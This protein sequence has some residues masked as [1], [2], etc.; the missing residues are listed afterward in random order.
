MSAQRMHRYRT[1][2][3][4]QEEGLGLVLPKGFGDDRFHRERNKQI[5]Q[6]ERVFETEVGDE[7]PI[8]KNKSDSDYADFQEDV[9]Y[10]EDR[11]TRFDGRLVRIWPKGKLEREALQNELL[12]LFRGKYK[13]RS[14]MVGRIAQDLGLPAK[15]VEARVN[16]LG[17][18]WQWEWTE[19]EDATII[20]HM[21]NARSSGRKLDY[22]RML[23]QFATYRPRT[24]FS[25]INR[26]E[27]IENLILRLREVFQVDLKSYDS[28]KIYALPQGPGLSAEQI[29][30]IKEYIKYYGAYIH[31]MEHIVC[32]LHPNKDEQMLLRCIEDA[33]NSEPRGF[34]VDEDRRL[35]CIAHEKREVTFNVFDLISK[36]L[37]S[38]TSEACEDRW[39]ELSRVI[40]LAGDFI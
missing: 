24:M 39:L 20:Q 26:I 33:Y 36:I 28:D 15:L 22:S 13:N 9:Q 23:L 16:N 21:R 6:R 40:N 11:M 12:E 4:T 2:S 1:R 18:V 35:L 17:R 29:N 3:R 10:D 31:Q 27:H 5:L 8:L 34:S 19:P 32:D 25:I 7:F 38:H 37:Q 14:F 30:Q